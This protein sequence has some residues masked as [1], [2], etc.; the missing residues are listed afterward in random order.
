MVSWVGLIGFVARL[1][2]AVGSAEAA[3]SRGAAIAGKT[4]MKTM[5]MAPRDCSG[6]S[7]PPGPAASLGRPASAAAGF[8]FMLGVNTPETDPLT[9][10][11]TEGAKAIS[12]RSSDRLNVTVFANSWLAGDPEMQS[13]VRAGGAIGLLA[14]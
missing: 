8:E 5:A 6:P 3:A 2:D 11:P 13:Q 9:I 1:P 14:A 12:E 10:G 7:L 4:I